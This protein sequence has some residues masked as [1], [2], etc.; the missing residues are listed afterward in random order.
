MR[1]SLMALFIV[2]FMATGCAGL[3]QV[4]TDLCR[5]GLG[6]SKAEVACDKVN[7]FLTDK[8]EDSSEDVE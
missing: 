5:V 3:T 1:N 4:A 2:L 8:E 6:G 7:E